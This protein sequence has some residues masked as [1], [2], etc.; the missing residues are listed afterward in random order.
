MLRGR[1]LGT[2]RMS[3]ADYASHWAEVLGATAGEADAFP[4][5][6]TKL[7]IRS[8]RGPARAVRFGGFGFRSIEVRDSTGLNEAVPFDRLVDIREAGG[9]AWN[10]RTLTDAAVGGRLPMFSLIRLGVGS[11]EI[12]V[13]VDQM[14]KAEDRSGHGAAT[15]ALVGLVFVAVLG[16]IAFLSNPYPY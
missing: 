16:I 8:G 5:P 7:T 1:Y 14:A 10:A 15:A 3:A 12:E 9:H 13:P 4:A 2:E 11:D 6:G